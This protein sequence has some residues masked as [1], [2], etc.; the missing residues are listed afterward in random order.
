MTAHDRPVCACVCVVLYER[1]FMR[2]HLAS[3]SSIRLRALSFSM[4]T[5]AV[6]AKNTS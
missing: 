1:V 3:A 4:M 6:S 5:L 2:K